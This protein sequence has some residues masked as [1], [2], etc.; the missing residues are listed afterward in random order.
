MHFVGLFLSSFQQLVNPYQSN[1]Q[2]NSTALSV[3]PTPYFQCFILG[4]PNCGILNS[5]LRYFPKKII[6]TKLLEFTI[7][8]RNRK[9]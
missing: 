1:V 2:F 5:K 9:D 3:L 6:V 4:L 7:K 8:I